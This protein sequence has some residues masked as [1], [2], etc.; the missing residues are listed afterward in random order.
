MA[1]SDDVEWL[2]ESVEPAEVFEEETAGRTA[3]RFPVVARPM[4]YGFRS[5]IEGGGLS[6]DPTPKPACEASPPRLHTKVGVPRRSALRRRCQ[7]CIGRFTERAPTQPPAAFRYSG[8]DLF[9]MV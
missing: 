7:Q 5:R 6:K 4:K 3:C 8:S 2:P 9:L 1:V